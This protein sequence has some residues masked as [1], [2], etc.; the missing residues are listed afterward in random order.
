ML[1]SAATAT[2]RMPTNSSYELKFFIDSVAKI[3]M[4]KHQASWG[5]CEE[6]IWQDGRDEVGKEVVQCRAFSGGSKH[7]QRPFRTTS[8]NLS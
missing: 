7:L 4:N 1:E 2:P 8:S 5:S 6:V 3:I